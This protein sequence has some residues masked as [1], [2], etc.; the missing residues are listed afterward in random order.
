[1]TSSRPHRSFRTHRRVTACAIALV[2]WLTT[3]QS[4]QSQEWTRFRGPNG[5]GISAASTIPVAFGSSDYNWRVAVP[6]IGHSSPVLWGSKIFL[7]SAEE[8]QGKRHVLCLDTAKGNI[9][10]TKSYPYKPYNRHEYNTAAS[11]T[12][13][14]DS[15]RVYTTWTT[16]ETFTVT[17][18][19]H[20]GKEV[21]S[22]DFGSFPTQH[23]G[24][25]SPML[26]GDLL[27]VTKEAENA[28][29]SILALNPKTGDVVWHHD[30]P[31][32]GMAPYA[33]PIIRKTTSGTEELLVANTTNGI[34][35]LNPRSGK[36]FWET[37]KIFPQR[38]V[39]GLVEA[40][41]HLIATCGNGAGFR[42]AVAVKPGP[43][44]TVAYQ[45][46][47]GTSYVPTPILSNGLLY[48]WHD[49]GIVLCV[50]PE[51]GD[52]VWQER[53]AAAMFFGSP[54]FVNGKLYAM[55]AKGEL[56]VLDAA[57]KFNVAARV[58]LGEPS[59]ATP[60]ISGGVMY[61]RTFGHLISV[62]GKQQ[63][64]KDVK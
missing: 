22:K 37:G 28:D 3:S 11:A 31:N 18:L 51:T 60:A 40:G 57:D 46:S 7:T 33:T 34:T 36:V 13:V 19:D 17:A 61:L 58:D 5:T 4:V 38:I 23:G 12:P 48:F 8:A 30:R 47:K 32:P 39:G 52:I 9:L 10:W 50:R 43:N 16:H 64:A 45:I 6:G 14:V 21:W 55:S 1:M 25:A 44:P 27:I 53:A 63:T 20:S 26:H 41:G 56:V 42:S 59:H 35:A 29:G 49:S 15:E 54:V 62:G 24:A 2:G